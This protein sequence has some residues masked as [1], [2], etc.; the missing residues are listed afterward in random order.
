MLTEACEQEQTFPSL[1]FCMVLDMIC[2]LL[3]FSCFK[4]RLALVIAVTRS[5]IIFCCKTYATQEACVR[6]SLS[7]QSRD[8]ANERNNETCNLFG[9][10]CGCSRRD[11]S[12]S[13]GLIVDTKS[14]MSIRMFPIWSW[15]ILHPLK[16]MVL[17][18]ITFLSLYRFD[19]SV[20]SSFI[21]AMLPANRMSS[22]TFTVIRPILPITSL[23]MYIW[24]IMKSIVNPARCTNQN[25]I[26]IAP[27]ASVMEYGSLSNRHSIYSGRSTSIGG[28]A[29][30]HRLLGPLCRYAP[31]ISI[32]P[33][34]K[35]KID[36][37]D[38]NRLNKSNWAVDESFLTAFFSLSL[39]PFGHNPAVIR[40]IQFCSFFT[41][42]TSCDGITF[43]R[44]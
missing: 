35:H 16:L 31:L 33:T 2:C 10:S 19:I 11:L 39:L 34:L 6:N 14:D 26:Y 32:H 21:H 24:L 12:T 8:P 3:S 37:R 4:W 42:Y 17:S 29:Y 20:E 18:I 15:V 36:A 9:F 23:L 38:R 40:F 22:I 44:S 13:I 41:L 25:S 30:I 7:K 28:R 5:F 43:V 1:Y 27:P